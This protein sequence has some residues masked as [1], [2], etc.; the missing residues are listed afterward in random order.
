MEG[1]WLLL[2]KIIFNLTILG[3]TAILGFY[4]LH[5]KIMYSRRVKRIK[6]QLGTKK[7]IA[8]GLDPE[9]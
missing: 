4:P 1:F 5:E 2:C 6:T 8:V 7:T 9:R 3:Q